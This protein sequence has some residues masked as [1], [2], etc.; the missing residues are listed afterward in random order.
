MQYFS[1]H[2]LPYMDTN[3]MQ[4][5][6]YHELPYM[7][8]NIMQYFSY[9]ELPYMDTNIMQYFS[10]S[11]YTHTTHTQLSALDAEGRAVLTEHACEVE[12][13]EGGRREGRVVVVNVYC[14]MVDSDNQE[15]MTYKL[16]FYQALQSRCA[17]LHQ[18]GK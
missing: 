5:F 1:Y 11:P 15:R 2:E 18:E 3:I 17:A 12:G 8:T 6:S 16:R 10:S 14:P 9:H 7:D 4:Y 13:E